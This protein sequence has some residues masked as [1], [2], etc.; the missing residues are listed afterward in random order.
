[1]NI[2]WIL[3]AL[4]S[5][6]GIAAVSFTISSLPN[7]IILFICFALV[8]G[9]FELTIRFL[10]RSPIHSKPESS[11]IL[12]SS[13]L[14]HKEKL[15]DG[16]YNFDI[17]FTIVNTGQNDAAKF[18]YLIICT[19]KQEEFKEF[20]LESNRTL[21]PYAVSQNQDVAALTNLSSNFLLNY[22]YFILFVEYL[23]VKN[24]KRDGKTFFR[25]I[26]YEKDKNIISTNLSFLTNE[27]ERE[28]IKLLHQNKKEYIGNNKIFRKT[29][30]E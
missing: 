29:L 26:F 7:K 8:A 11:I 9:V 4:A 20:E 25:K 24:N 28:I 27:E 14:K 15:T 30:E 13:S 19:N 12:K 6:S 3:H 18:K 16:Q 1:M 21:A 5:I 10:D 22:P 23:D 2:Q 17:K